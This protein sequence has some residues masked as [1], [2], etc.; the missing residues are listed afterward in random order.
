[1]PE[2]QLK[3]RAA[4]IGTA[5]SADPTVPGIDALPPEA[6]GAGLKFRAGRIGQSRTTP[7]GLFR[8]IEKA[9]QRLAGGV[10]KSR[11]W[12]VSLDRSINR[13]AVSMSEGTVKSVGKAELKTIREFLVRAARTGKAKPG[14]IGLM[15][16]SALI[17]TGVVPKAETGFIKR[18][19]QKFG[20]A[21]TATG[22]KQVGTLGKIGRFAGRHVAPY[23]GLMLAE[24]LLKGQKRKQGEQAQIRQILEEQGRGGTSA[25]GPIQTVEFIEAMG[26]EFLDA[27][28]QDPA[29]AIALQDRLQ[30]AAGGG[31]PPGAA[32]LRAE[33]PGGGGGMDI[34]ALLAQ[35]G[36]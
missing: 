16:S 7:E 34:E 22:L 17:E 5:F 36:G 6:P 20:A 1:M 24:Q 19:A 25:F 8:S 33:G 10:G 23:A 29:L 27:I 35:M 26:P 28:S 12:R 32:V 4:A 18:I 30:S 11:V 21:G 2:L 14:D 15:A 9:S 3:E 13:L 31:L